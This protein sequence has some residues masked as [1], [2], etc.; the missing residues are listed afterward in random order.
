MRLP[1][2]IVL[3]GGTSTGRVRLNDCFVV[4][5]PRFFNPASAV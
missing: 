4:D 3:Q 5:S 2:R 1:N